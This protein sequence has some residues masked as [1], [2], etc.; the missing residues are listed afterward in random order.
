M[1]V[2]ALFASR[3]KRIDSEGQ[4]F[5]ARRA[6][7]CTYQIAPKLAH[8]CSIASAA[9]GAGFGV[10]INHRRAVSSNSSSAAMAAAGE[11]CQTLGPSLSSITARIG[12]QLPSSPPS[13]AQPDH[14]LSDLLHA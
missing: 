4:H 9:S 6:P 7:P 3:W 11:L 13:I 14:R 12:V 2:P 1:E 8:S 5:A 10:V